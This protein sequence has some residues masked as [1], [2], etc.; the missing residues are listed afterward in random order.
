MSLSTHCTGHITTGS[1]YGRR[2]PVHTVGVSRFCTVNCRPTASNYQF[3]TWGQAGIQTRI[4]EW[5]RN[6]RIKKLDSRISPQWQIQAAPLGQFHTW[7]SRSRCSSSDSRTFSHWK[8]NGSRYTCIKN[9]DREQQW[10]R[11]AEPIVL[12]VS[13]YL[14]SEVKGLMFLV[15]FASCFQTVTVI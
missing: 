7:L 2:K 11:I 6:W 10:F 13:F 5:D 3:P 1:F 14:I 15:V 12:S 9:F 8:P 4:S